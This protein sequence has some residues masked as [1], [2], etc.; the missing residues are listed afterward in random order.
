MDLSKQ[1]ESLSNTRAK[2]L[3]ES[4]KLVTLT[5]ELDERLRESEY[6]TAITTLNTILTDSVNL[7]LELKSM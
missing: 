7:M 2:F 1:D 5:T 4:Q 6:N 3:I